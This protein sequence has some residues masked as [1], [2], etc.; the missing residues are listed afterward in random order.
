MI[1]K[2]LTAIKSP[3]L[4][5]LRELTENN[6]EPYSLPAGTAVEVCLKRNGSHIGF[7]FLS[8]PEDIPET[9]GVIVLWSAVPI[10]VDSSFESD[11]WEAYLKPTSV[12]LLRSERVLERLED[13]KGLPL[14]ARNLITEGLRY[15][16]GGALDEM[17]SKILADNPSLEVMMQQQGKTT[18]GFDIIF[19]IKS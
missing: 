2:F 7:K 5:E 3:S 4:S 18:K 12:A 11:G 8:S 1:E 10:I 16:R 15:I 19:H 17:E 9:V 6:T 14:D 13:I